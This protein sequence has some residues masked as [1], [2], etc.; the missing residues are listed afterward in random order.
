MG[1]TLLGSPNQEIGPHTD[2]RNQ[3]PRGGPGH[4]QSSSECNNN[5]ITVIIA[6]I[7]VHYIIYICILHILSHLICRKKILRGRQHC[8]PPAKDT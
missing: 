4:G 1:G 6:H 7:Y 8:Y 5:T 3:L 2:K